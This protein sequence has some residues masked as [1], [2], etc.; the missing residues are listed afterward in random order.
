MTD[1]EQIV[2]DAVNLAKRF[3]HEYVTIE[4]ISAVALEDNNIRTMCYEVQADALGLQEALLG[5]LTEDC[6]E[7]VIDGDVEVFED[8]SDTLLFKI[9][10][11]N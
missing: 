5:Y 9:I 4:H 10:S 7:L 1:I 2:A 11:R 8:Y 6:T 3:Q